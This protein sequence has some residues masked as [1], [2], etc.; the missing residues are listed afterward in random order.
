MVIRLKK[1]E[2]FFYDDI[3][4]KAMPFPKL[5]TVDT[6]PVCIKAQQKNQTDAKAM[7]LRD[8]QVNQPR[9]LEL[10]GRGSAVRCVLYSVF[11]YA[12]SKFYRC[13]QYPSK[14]EMF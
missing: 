9:A 7:H 12:C 5:K 8:N 13:G 2:N 1:G 6:T 10:R 14:I 3:Y 11:I 4:A